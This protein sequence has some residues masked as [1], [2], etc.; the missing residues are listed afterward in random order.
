MRGL[1]GSEAGMFF[2][3]GV[4]VVVGGAKENM[5]PLLC[6][7]MP[8]TEGWVLFGDREPCRRGLKMMDLPRWSTSRPP[9]PPPP[10]RSCA[11]SLL[12]R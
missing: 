9:P 7:G 8:L 11:L 5:V 6:Q 2:D 3:G 4:V 10:L 12:S 1:G